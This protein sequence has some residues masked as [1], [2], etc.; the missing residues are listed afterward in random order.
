MKIKNK[1]TKQKIDKKEQL[2][3]RWINTKKY[4]RLKTQKI[5]KLSKKED[6]LYNRNL[7]Y[8]NGIPKIEDDKYIYLKNIMMINYITKN[9]C[10]K[11][12]KGIIN[13]YGNNPLRG[14]VG[15][16]FNPKKLKKAIDDF[17]YSNNSER[18]MRLCE[19]SP[20]ENIL[21]EYINY[22][23]ISIF[24]ASNDM[25]GIIFNLHLTN[26]AQDK[27]LEIMNE[28]VVV[29]PVY[30]IYKYKKRR[31]ISITELSSES[32]RNNDYENI[33]LEIKDRCNKLFHKY[34][35]LELEYNNNA[36]ISLDIYQTNYDIKNSESRFL[37]SL[38]F[39]STSIQEKDEI[40][41]CV[42]E[43]NKSDDFIKTK[44]YYEISLKKDNINRSNNI[45]YYIDNKK[46]SIISGGSE[47]VNMALITIAFYELEEMIKD[48]SMERNRLFSTNQGKFKKTYSQFCILNNKIHRYRMIYNGIKEHYFEYSD[49]YLKRGLENLKR[50]YK[51]YYNQYKELDKEYQFRMNINNSRSS[52]NFSKV[53]III[54]ILALLLTIY[55][56]YRKNT[57]DNYYIYIQQCNR[58]VNEDITE[59]IKEKEITN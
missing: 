50:R 21:Y 41:V 35:P 7:L 34:I 57:E 32:I 48:I 10:N 11:L 13:L 12:Y 33:L 47:Y 4:I 31:N 26:F 42:R 58:N 14:F 53:S 54:A 45:F 43:K 52:Y 36:P 6:W 29:K 37:N 9:N 25:I 3:N 51:E 59:L 1:Y 15:G 8:K 17:S 2:I 27:L 22:I 20:K 39:Y 40:S 23:D 16:G 30:S 44:M 5:V 56:E 55:F 28:D 46:L 24:E 38:D 18:W 49:D 19:I